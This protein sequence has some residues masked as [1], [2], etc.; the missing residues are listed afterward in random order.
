VV[1]PAVPKVGS[2]SVSANIPGAKIFIDGRNDPSWVTPFT[3]PNLP[4][5]AHN[6]RIAMDGYDNSQQSVT[7]E[8]G[9]TASVSAN[10]TTPTAELDVITNPAGVEILVDGKS[11]G[12]SP[13]HATLPPGNHTYT[14]KWAGIPP[15]ESSVTLEGGQIAT[16]RL[17]LNYGK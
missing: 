8:A 10:L 1:Q 6:V 12:P 13:V 16:K 17:S 4:V 9:K 14:I 15:T 2:V 11:Y 3:I 7:I 5:G